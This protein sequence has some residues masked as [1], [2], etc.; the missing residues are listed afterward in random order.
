MVRDEL[1]VQ[2]ERKAVSGQAE[3][4]LPPVLFVNIKLGDIR[5]RPVCKRGNLE[6]LKIGKVFL[7]LQDP[8][9]VKIVLDDRFCKS[10]LSGKFLF[11]E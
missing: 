2:P 7:R 3:P 10:D 9:I 11:R 8:R 5:L 1:S 6:P 4:D